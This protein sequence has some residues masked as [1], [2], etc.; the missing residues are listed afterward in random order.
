MTWCPEDFPP[1]WCRATSNRAEFS[2]TESGRLQLAQ[3]LVD[4]R[5]PLVARV[6]VNR[7]WRWHFGRGLVESTD[8]FGQLG[9]R[10]DNQPLLDW[11]ASS[12][13]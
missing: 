13:C 1:C 3:W 11:L 2:D 7:L 12:F 9:D 8:N 4:G 10:P 6:M 5:H